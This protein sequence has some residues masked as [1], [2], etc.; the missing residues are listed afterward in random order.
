MVDLSFPTF[1]LCLKAWLLPLPTRTVCPSFSLKWQAHFI[2]FW[3]SEVGGAGMR[4]GWF[5][6]SLSDSTLKSFQV[7]QLWQRGPRIRAGR[8]WSPGPAPHSAAEG[9]LH[10]SCDHLPG[11][12]LQRGN[13]GF[14]VPRRRS[15][16][17]CSAGW[18][19]SLNCL[20]CETE[21]RT[22]TFN[23]NFLSTCFLPDSGSQQWTSLEK[24]MLWWWAQQGPAVKT[25]DWRWENRGQTWL[26]GVSSYYRR[27]LGHRL[28]SWPPSLWSFSS[29]RIP[30][31]H[32]ITTTLIWY[33]IFQLTYCV[34][35]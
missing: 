12:C 25:R 9:K 5:A 11:R 17:H 21:I 27:D 19:Q 15:T 14:S 20:I 22:A 2:H 35:K 6:F 33:L 4:S 3:E 7:Q 31:N 32:Q 26:T 1:D 10:L 29:P 34:A 16:D 24:L 8:Q 13:T 30:N 18:T 28:I 23:H